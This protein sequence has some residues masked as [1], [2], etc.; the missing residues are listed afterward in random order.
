MST[1]RRG[2]LLLFL[3]LTLVR[4]LIYAAIIPPW[5]APDE[6]GHFEYIWL[7]VN[8]G[9]LPAI[10]DVSPTLEQE[11]LGSLYE[12]RYGDFTGRPL[13]GEMP[14]RMSDLPQSVFAQRSRPILLERPSL[15]Y[16]WSALFLL[17]FRHQ[18]LVSQLYVTR[19]SQVF[20]NICIVW[21]AYL[22]FRELVPS[23]PRLV[24][25][26]TAMVVFIPQHTFVNSA[27]G[28][29]PLAET[30]AC[31]VL[32]CWARLLRRGFRAWEAVGIAL[33]TL[34][35]VWTKTTAAFLIPVNV[36]L[37]LWLF[38]RKYGRTWTR[39]QTAYLCVGIAA[40]GIS[41]WLWSGSPLGAR[42]FRSIGLLFHPS[43]WTW[44]DER[45]ITF[46]KALLQFYDNIWANFGWMAVSV[47][48]RWYGA[49]TLLSL[50]ALV[51]WAASKPRR[52]IFSW[53][54]G[55]MG[56]TALVAWLIAAWAALLAQTEGF[57]QAQGR[58]LF[59]AVIPYA[60]L[61]VGGLDRLFPTRLRNYAAASL[62]LFLVCF[63]AVCLASYILPFFY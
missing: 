16:L 50:A 47:S 3:A 17:P 51:G 41:I 44:V 38:L 40:F 14:A 37:A 42:T 2:L 39:R 36:G 11:I 59:P 35:G 6:T 19:L 13:P 58:Y 1:E 60:F 15:S 4:G 23:R 53:P 52:S 54:V 46:G 33:G 5:Q 18:D 27:V 22:T 63:D 43:E 12:W 55:F 32:Y 10:E 45:G 31:L 24:V 49:I 57:Y 61:L 21:L 29:G 25:L 34:I 30:M 48:E 56:G 7:V 8:L 62:L 26:M 28:E 9:R 20:L